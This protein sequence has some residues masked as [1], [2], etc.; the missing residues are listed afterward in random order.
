MRIKLQIIFGAMGKDNG[1][2]LNPDDTGYLVF[3]KE[4]DFYDK[5]T[6]VW[7]RAFCTDLLKQN[8]LARDAVSRYQCYFDQFATILSGPCKL[9]S[10]FSNNTIDI[11]PCC[12]RPFPADRETATSCLGDPNIERI[13]SG[14]AVVGQALYDN[15]R[16]VKVFRYIVECNQTMGDLSAD[17]A[18]MSSFYKS[19]ASYMRESLESAPKGIKTGWFT[20]LLGVEFLYYDL[21]TSLAQG[22]IFAISLAMGAGFI[23]MLVTSLNILITIYA[24]VTIAFVIA[25]TVAVFVFQGWELG[26]GESFTITLAVGLSIDFTVHYGVAY[27]VSDQRHRKSRVYDTIAT[28]GFAVTMAAV[29]TFLSGA[30]MMAGRLQSYRRFGLFLMIT[31]VTS[32]VYAT[33]FFLPVCRIIDPNEQFGDIHACCK[34]KHKSVEQQDE[35]NHTADKQTDNDKV[36]NGYIQKL[37][38]P[39][40]QN[41]SAD[42]GTN[43]HHDD[44]NSKVVESKNNHVTPP[45]HIYLPSYGREENNNNYSLDEGTK[46]VIKHNIPKFRKDYNDPKFHWGNRDFIYYTS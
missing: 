7:L 26:L 6:Q 8:F 40:T 15:K 3:D 45:R 1:N 20:G 24:M 18:K 29:T 19:V 27:K 35:D 36:D 42:L 28:V 14:T 34:C 32:W 4:F 13:L 22:S 43:R 11:S 17:Y 25:V 44:S 10:S 23:V 5:A 31:M 46:N 16:N 9:Y 38:W 41:A 37:S 21:Q 39:R 33:F 12:G 2:Y 30:A